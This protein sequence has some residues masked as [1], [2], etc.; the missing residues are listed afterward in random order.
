[1]SKQIAN[2]E[3]STDSFGAWVSVTNIIADTISTVA[4][5]T[6]STASGANTVGNTNII[7]KLSANTLATSLLLG[8][9]A[10]NT[11]NITA[12]TIGFSN[13][14]VSSNVTITGYTTDITSN[15]TG[16]SSNISFT[17]ANVS[18][19][20]ANV[21][22]SGGIL[23]I[24]SNTNVTGPQ[25]T[26][27]GNLAFSGTNAH[28][29]TAK[30]TGGSLVIGGEIRTGNNFYFNSNSSSFAYSEDHF[31]YP[32]TGS[33]ANAVASFEIAD[34]KSAK[35][36]VTV[37]NE[38]N[39]NH[40]LFTEISSVI[41]AVNANVYYTEYG[42]IFSNTRFMSF[43]VDANTTHINLNGTANSSVTNTFVTVLISKF[44]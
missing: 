11:A 2:V 32:G 19:N 31:L 40:V 10:G 20:T 39:T 4:V 9:A 35:F 27:S 33:V 7:G 18:F 5:T 1:M 44:K 17:G 22:V 34:H 23:N 26:V 12:L 15:S 38:A 37:K 29:N 21:A 43:T 16:I 6:D 3:I 30:I 41:D 24:S 36:T 25:V 42:T 14:T 28:F 8:G 13:S